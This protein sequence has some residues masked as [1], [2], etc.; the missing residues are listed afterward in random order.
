[1]SLT[2]T[3]EARATAMLQALPDRKAAAVL[4]Y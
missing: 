3:W 2:A 1:M 4:N